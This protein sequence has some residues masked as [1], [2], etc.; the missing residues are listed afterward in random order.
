MKQFSRL[1]F[2]IAATFLLLPLPAG[3]YSRDVPYLAGRVN[4][5]AGLLSPQAVK[6]LEAVLKAHED[7]TSNQVVVLTIPGLEGDDLEEF[8]VK[9]AETWKIGQKEKDNGVLLLIAVHDRQVRIEVGS[10]LEGDLP[11]ITCGTIIRSEIIPRFRDGD[12]EAGIRSG[13]HAILRSIEGSYSPEPDDLPGFFTHALAFL[14]FL[15]VVGI[16]TVMGLLSRG[17]QSWFLFVFL[18]PFWLFFPIIF[19]GL[20][21]GIVLCALYMIG[22]VTTKTWFVKS[23]TGKSLQERWSSR[24][25]FIPTGGSGWSSGRSGWSSGGGFSGGGGGFSGGGAS[26][27]W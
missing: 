5:T 2:S 27:G 7:S 14:L 24:V 25:G 16:F 4:D 9:V 11:D 13:V 6:E 3:V 17:F 10:G 26:G 19:F 12:Y 20:E 15:V 18:I 1:P 23:K 8:S 21:A 22:F